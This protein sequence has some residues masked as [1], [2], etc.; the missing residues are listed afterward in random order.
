MRKRKVGLTEK[1][2]EI[3]KE[4]A[5]LKDIES[6]EEKEKKEKHIKELEHELHH[7]EEDLQK[8]FKEFFEGEGS[9][10]KKI[11]LLDAHI[12][13]YK[14]GDKNESASSIQSYDK[15]IKENS[16]FNRED[17]YKELRK[18]SLN[19]HASL[20]I[21]QVNLEID[22][23][24]N[25]N[26]GIQI[27]EEFEQMMSTV[28]IKDLD[29]NEDELFE[30][31]NDLNNELKKTYDLVSRRF[32]GFKANVLDRWEKWSYKELLPK[33]VEAAAKDLGTAFDNVIFFRD[34]DNPDAFDMMAKELPKIKADFRSGTY[35]NKHNEVVNFIVVNNI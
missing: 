9:I 7:S 22:E 17:F 30:D 10:H 16:Q 28:N 27:D 32:S 1:E 6:K 33:E 29:L 12:K 31:R 3:K 15:F 25:T 35:K 21:K 14:Q 26:M 24:L 34:S 20:R 2:A 4:K 8:E 13:A 5:E 23:W 19:E 11:T 18:N